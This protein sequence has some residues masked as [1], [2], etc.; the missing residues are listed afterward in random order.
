MGHYMG[1]VN[2]TMSGYW[3]VNLTIKDPDGNLMNNTIKFAM[4]I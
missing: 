1:E 3:E 2:F 4:T